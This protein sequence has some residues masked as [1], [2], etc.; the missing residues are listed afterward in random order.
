MPKLGS[1]ARTSKRSKTSKKFKG[2]ARWKSKE[3][4]VVTTTDSPNSH[5]F[6]ETVAE[7][8]NTIGNLDAQKGFLEEELGAVSSAIR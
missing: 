7:T 6:P 3:G 1:K 8:P 2:V 4:S 5:V